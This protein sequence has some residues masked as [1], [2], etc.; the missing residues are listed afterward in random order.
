M[1]KNRLPQRIVDL[2]VQFI[3]EKRESPE[4]KTKFPNALLR[5]DVLD[6]LD[7]Y[8]IVIYYPLE[9][10]SNNGFH[11]TGITD[12]FGN[13]KHFV[14]INTNQTIDKQIFTAAHEL[15]HVWEVDAYVDKKYAVNSEEYDKEDIIN[16]FAAELLMPK[17]QFLAVFD[18]ECQKLIPENGKTPLVNLLKII[19]TIMNHFY[20]PQKAV[21]Y[22]FFE[23]EL[24][25]TQ[26][27]NLLLG[28][29]AIPEKVISNFINETMK[30]NG[31]TR[32]IIPDQKKWI[33]GLSELLETAENNQTL[34]KQK[35]ENMR[36][37]FEMPKKQDMADVYEEIIDV[38]SLEG[39]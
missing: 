13:E 37:L 18:N 12:K 36:K 16:R 33:G 4:I 21:I 9:N 29:G 6:L 2:I 27:L 23:L 24:I 28:E 15:G 14:Y 35:I 8:C 30:E 22:R 3:L 17:Q 39:E 10:E 20:V 34:P 38:S 5:S 26:T 7:V 31:H 1:N 32:F 25:N 19:A 11:I